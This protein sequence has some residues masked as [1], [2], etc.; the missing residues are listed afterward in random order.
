MTISTLV[1]N[2]THVQVESWSPQQIPSSLKL[3]KSTNFY[4]QKF[5]KFPSIGQ[6][7]SLAE[8]YFAALLESKRDVTTFVPQPFRFRIGSRFFIPD[9][10]YVE[11]G[12]KTIVEL[13]AP[14]GL[15]DNR[16]AMLKDECA[17]NGYEFKLVPNEQIYH[18]EIMA[19]NWLTIVRVLISHSEIDT[20]SEQREI[21]DNFGIDQTFA[22]SKIVDSG[23]R[24]NTLNRE[25]ALFRLLHLGRVSAELSTDTLNYDTQ[26]RTLL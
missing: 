6:F 26:F 12:Q 24:L 4:E 21:F 10:F 17:S 9:F 7:H 14:S 3:L 8:L 11:N 22:F 13:K 2:F 18:Q 15:E 19:E 20:K 25:V 1:R 16:W 5:L 23:D